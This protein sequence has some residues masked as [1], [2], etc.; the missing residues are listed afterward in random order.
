MNRIMT[1]SARLIFLAFLGFLANGHAAAAA[2]LSDP[3]WRL[4]LTGASVQSTGGGGFNSSIGGGL[5]LE[6]RASEH[7]GFEIGAVSSQINDELG[8]GLF[9]DDDF[10]IESSLRITPLLARLNFHLTPGHK[11]DLYLGPVA[12]WV[13]YGDINVRVRVPGEGSILA[14]HVT[15]KDG[16]AAGA[17][18]GLDVPFGSR[19]F[20]FT[21]DATYLKATV[22]P[23][24]K[25]A[26]A[27]ALDFDL[28]PVIVQVGLGYRF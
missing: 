28:D 7:F 3:G 27:G 24:A 17:H 23:D 11:A 22:K 26:A 13:R 15:N 16:F 18:I 5:G 19:G 20:F 25:S 6:Y 12:G 1:I 8:F 14:D 4:K 2:D 21:S 10:T 9:G